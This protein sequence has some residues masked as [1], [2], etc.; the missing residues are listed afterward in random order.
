MNIGYVASTMI[1]G[2]ILL[3][4]VTLNLRV[5]QNSGEQTLYN[6]AKIQADMIAEYVEN[7]LRSIGYGIQ[8]T[9][10]VEADSNSIRFLVHFEGDEDPTEISWTFLADSTS[11]YQNPAIRPLNRTENSDVH[12]IGVG[13][14][15]FRL[16]YLD[17]NREVLNP[18]SMDIS[19][20]RQIRISLITE[21]T[22][23]YGEDRFGRASW[24]AEIT[25][26]NL[27]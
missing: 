5:S 8:G 7:D 6:M 22:Q 10:I 27:H 1:A 11:T 19:Q 4:L 16:V 2:I 3:S 12:N 21:S 9:P 24:T 26:Y 13:V 15:R 23:G 20:I 18:L 25:P 17:Q 14:T